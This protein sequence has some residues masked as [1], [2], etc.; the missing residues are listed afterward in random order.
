[1]ARAAE[2]VKQMGNHKVLLCERG[3]SFG[4]S[5]LIVDYRNLIWMKESSK[6]P[7]VLDVTHCLQQPSAR[8]TESGELVSG[9]ADP[10]LIPAMG[11]AA[12]AMGVDGLFLEVDEDPSQ[13][14]CDGKLQW[15]IDKLDSLLHSWTLIAEARQQADPL[16]EP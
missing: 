1:M 8:P 9:A 7:V 16:P 14:P 6:L 15:P 13:A 3:N 11:C 10:R 12:L 5:D 2:K 4:Y